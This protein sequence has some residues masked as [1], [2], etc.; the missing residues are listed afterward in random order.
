M[1]KFIKKVFIVTMSFFSCNTLKCVSMNNQECKVR[2][3]II[4]INSNG[5]SFYPYR[6]KISTCSGGCNNTNDPYTKLYVP[7]IVKNMNIKVFNLVKNMNI[8][9]FNLISRANETRYK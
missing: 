6:V 9:V 7:Y 5:P 4:N 1:F 2:P 8:K 3:K